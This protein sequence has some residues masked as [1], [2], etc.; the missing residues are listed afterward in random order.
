MI[1]S[2]SSTQTTLYDQIKYQGSPA[3]FAWVLPISGEAKV[4][5]SADT[6]F[7]ALDST[8]QTQVFAPP[9]NC[10]PPPNCNYANDGA[11]GAPQASGDAGSSGG[12]IVTHQETVGPYATVQL[13]ATNPTALNDWLT[14]N[15]YRVPAD[16]QPI[17]AQYVN[18]QFSFLAMKL[19]PGANITS[20]R[21]VRVT[22]LGASPVLP[23]RM[24]AA[25]T[26]PVVGITLWV[27][28]EGRY[29]PHNFP[30]FTVETDELIWDWNTGSSNYKVLR[31]EKTAA[32]G[33]KAWEVE[34]SIDVSQSQIKNI[35]TYGSP[36]GGAPQPGGDYLPVSEGGA[37]TQT[38]EQ[39]RDAD[40]ATL[41]SGIQGSEAR[42]TR[43]RADLNHA[44]LDSDLYV[45]AP[46]D[47]RTVPTVRQV[48]REA[49]QPQCP[50]Y[51]GCEAVGTKPRDEAQADADMKSTSVMGSSEC[52]V[53]NSARSARAAERTPYAFVF[54]LGFAAVSL[55]RGRRKR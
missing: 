33:G 43:L 46:S 13:S 11:Q 31:A 39:A 21:P 22:T 3:S 35:V 20:M 17:I 19:I 25:G 44:A 28:G 6:V 48:T 45:S 9:L 27:V 15:G 29:E 7:G 12:V 52:A 49:N 47:Q 5:L 40:L 37:V 54:A 30:F 26:G 14:E 10:P 42:I 38:A 55:V 51:Q 24:V 36:F 8:T 18:E 1:L 34:S 50:I 23:L 53:T 41:F 16:V 4:A 2:V 32:S